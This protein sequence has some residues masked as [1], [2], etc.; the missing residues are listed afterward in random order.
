MVI[1]LS[2]IGFAVLPPAGRE[3]E[4]GVERDLA[5]LLEPL[6]PVIEALREPFEQVT[7]LVG[8]LDLDAL[9]DRVTNAQA[10][11]D[12]VV[13]IAGLL[14]AGLVAGRVVRWIVR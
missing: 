1:P 7:A 13:R 14:V 8:E 3:L 5:S 11:E 4:D 9:K 6:E 12:P 2:G 10:G